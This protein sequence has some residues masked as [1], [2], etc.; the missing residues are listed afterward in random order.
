M[1]WITLSNGN[2]ILVSGIVGGTATV[3][4][5]VNGSVY[6]TTTP[7][8]LVDAAEMANALESGETVRVQVSGNQIVGFEV[9]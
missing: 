8:L 9:V 1:T 5:T 7:E 3:T 6:S 2:A 4:V